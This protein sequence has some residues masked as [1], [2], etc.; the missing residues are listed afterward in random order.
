[1]SRKSERLVNLTI[2]LLHSKRPLTKS[3]IFNKVAG[4]EGTAEAMERMFERDKELLRSIGVPIETKALD[5]YFDDEMGYRVD[6]SQYAID[7]GEIDSTDISLLA[8]ALRL[9]DNEK[10]ELLLRIRSLDNQELL[11][12]GDTPKLSSMSQIEE[13]VQAIEKRNQVTFEY[14]TTENTAAVRNVY[15]Y[16]LYSQRG[17]WY[18][19]AFDLDRQDIRNF[20]ISRMFS[21]IQ[22]SSK[23]CFT[24]PAHMDFRS[25]IEMRPEKEAVLLARR[26]EA[27]SLRSRASEITSE[28]DWDTLSVKYHD[29]DWLVEEILWHLDSVVAL[30]PAGLRDRVIS[31]LQEVVATHE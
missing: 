13:L 30:K 5:N 25:Y 8:M 18:L 29:E 6:S 21:S 12:F 11:H 16:Y 2:A 28:E 23:T 10:D 22:V 7:L 9:L 20:K 19:L 4:Y 15:P 24:F 14:L 31:S 26:G 27:L 17:D 1:M 3:E